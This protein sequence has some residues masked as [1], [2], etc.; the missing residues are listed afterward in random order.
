M[1]FKISDSN[2]FVG[3]VLE[4]YVCKVLSKA[5]TTSIHQCAAK[6]RFHSWCQA[7]GLYGEAMNERNT[8]HYKGSC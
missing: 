2:T 1:S 5:G 7:M 8:G 6:L 3:H 4:C